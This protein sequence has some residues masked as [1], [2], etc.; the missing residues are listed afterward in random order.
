MD[1]ERGW[2]LCCNSALRAANLRKYHP[3]SAREFFLLCPIYNVTPFFGSISRFL[4]DGV[5]RIGWRELLRKREIVLNIL[6]VWMIVVY[7]SVVAV[8]LFYIILIFLKNFVSKEYLEEVFAR[9]HS[10]FSEFWNDL[11]K[12]WNKNSLHFVLVVFPKFERILGFPFSFFPL[13][14]NV[15]IFE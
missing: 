5:R 11:G 10:S 3:V 13:C 12:F 14:L 4:A 9:F 2:F 1:P 7:Y 15:A 8:L 6:L